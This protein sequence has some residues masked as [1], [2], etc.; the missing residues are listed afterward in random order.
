MLAVMRP[1]RVRRSLGLL[2][3]AVAAPVLAACGGGGSTPVAPPTPPPPPP[4]VTSPI[5][6]G[7]TVSTRGYSGGTFT[8]SF[9][10][11]VPSGETFTV[12]RLAA[13]VPPSCP[14]NTPCSFALPLGPVDAVAVTVGPAALP[15]SAIT[16]VALS[17]FTLSAASFTL[18]DTTVDEGT[19][20]FSS[21]PAGGPLVETHALPDEGAPIVTLQPNRRYVLTLWGFA[22]LDKPPGAIFIPPGGTVATTIPETGDT[23]A[24]AFGNPIPA[25]EWIIFLPVAP[26]NVT[27]PPGTI[28]AISFEIYPKQMPASVIT[29]VMLSTPRAFSGTRLEAGLTGVRNE[30][31][32]STALPFALAPPGAPPNPSQLTFQ[33]GPDYGASLTALN[34]GISYVLSIRTY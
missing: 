3:C 18:T 15:L 31:G 34:P 5:A 28:D 6:P 26:L 10:P 12:G 30:S 19:T 23:I 9:G 29:G 32:L 27:L 8:F 16:N 4:P 22:S 33:T 21:T 25:K 7:A 11:G 2:A 1:L 14:P 24:V 17:G 13:P 20:S